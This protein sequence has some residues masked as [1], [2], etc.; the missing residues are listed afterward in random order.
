MEPSVRLRGSYRGAF[1]KFADK[2]QEFL[3]LKVEDFDSCAGFLAQLQEKYSKIETIDK[4]IL[5]KLQKDEKCSQQM[6]D[7]EIEGI[8]NYNGTF[9]DL[10]TRL[11]CSL[12]TSKELDETRSEGET[13]CSKGNFKLPKIEL[14]KFDGNLKNYLSFWGLFKKI[15]EDPNI[16]DLDKF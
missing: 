11:E 1:T 7:E 6:L 15:R 14:Q 12:N 16:S 5:D 3:T 4:E 13:G 10:K 2:V 8:E 9:V